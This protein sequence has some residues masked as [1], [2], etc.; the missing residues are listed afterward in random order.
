M[1]VL[2]ADN[3][4]GWSSEV[5]DGGVWPLDKG[6]GGELVLLCFP[7]LCVSCVC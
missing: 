6:Q 1:L 7:P 2:G 3:K 4:D 5:A